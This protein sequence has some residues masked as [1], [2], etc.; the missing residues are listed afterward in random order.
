V[1]KKG[2]KLMIL[3]YFTRKTGSIYNFSYIVECHGKRL[4]K[5]RN[6]MGHTRVLGNS[7]LFLSDVIVDIYYR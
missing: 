6:N 1:D 5:I 4:I 2:V 3:L 7:L